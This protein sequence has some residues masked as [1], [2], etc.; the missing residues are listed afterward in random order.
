MEY[1]NNY[2]SGVAGYEMGKDYITVV[3]KRGGVPYTYSYATAGANA[4]ETMKGLAASQDG[5]NTFINKN[6]PG[7]VKG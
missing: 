2:E 3:F 4:V 5:L 7:F 1:Y 6:K